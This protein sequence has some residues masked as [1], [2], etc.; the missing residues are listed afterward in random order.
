[1]NTAVGVERTG[2]FTSPIVAD[3]VAAQAN[4]EKEDGIAAR[5]EDRAEQGR[6]GKPREEI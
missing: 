5:N 2:N 1:M 4:D 3:G 6:S